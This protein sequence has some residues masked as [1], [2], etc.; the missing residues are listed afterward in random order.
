MEP[1]RPHVDAYL[2]DWVTRQP[3]RRE[4][5][6]EQGDRNC[7]LTA[8]FAVSLSETVPIWQRAV[9]P[10]AEWFARAIWSPIRRPDTP[11]ATRRL[12]ATNVHR[13]ARRPVHHA[14]PLSR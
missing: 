3:L 14:P 5:F 6:S 12:K 10:I 1:I 4:W 7:R 8:S 9:A 11:L 2:L 13:K